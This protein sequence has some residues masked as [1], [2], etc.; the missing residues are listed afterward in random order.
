MAKKESR[1]EVRIKFY[2]EEYTVLKELAN[3]KGYCLSEFLQE[4][5]LQACPSHL[6]YQR[7]ISAAFAV[8][9]G[10][11]DRVTAEAKAAAVLNTIRR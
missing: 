9:G 5:S 3:S 8:S 2:D 4:L 1:R 7:A 10:S 6:N 11:V